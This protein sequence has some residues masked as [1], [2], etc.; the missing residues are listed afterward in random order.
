MPSLRNIPRL[1][2]F[3]FHPI[4]NGLLNSVILAIALSVILGIIFFFT[5]MQETMLSALSAVIIVV[6]VFWGGRIT[7]K[8]VGSKGLLFGASV[9]LTFFVLT[10]IIAIFDG[11]TITFSAIVK[12]L[13][14]CLVAGALGG[15]FGV[16]EK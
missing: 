7:A 15:I 3:K 13:G 11:T 8:S 16:S 4:L 2:S 12:Q 6:S 10:G 9:G 5:P 1:T 14:L